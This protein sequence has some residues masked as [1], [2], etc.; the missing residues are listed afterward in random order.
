MRS[1]VRKWRRPHDPNFAQISREARRG[2]RDMRRLRPGEVVRGA[3]SVVRFLM[4]L[5]T[6]S[7]RML[8]ARVVADASCSAIDESCSKRGRQ[9]AQQ[10]SV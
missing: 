1:G 9:A 10:K 7:K 8:A 6:V 5:R 4:A 2:R 3:S